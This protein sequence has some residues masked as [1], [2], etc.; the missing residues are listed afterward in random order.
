VLGRLLLKPPSPGDTGEEK[1]KVARLLLERGVQ[2]TSKE[3]E[4]TQVEVLRWFSRLGKYSKTDFAIADETALAMIRLLSAQ[5]CAV[6]VIYH[7]RSIAVKGN[8]PV[9]TLCVMYRVQRLFESDWVRLVACSSPRVMTYYVTEQELAL[10]DRGNG[11][12]ALFAILDSNTRGHHRLANVRALI[13]LGLNPA[14]M[15]RPGARNESPAHAL[16]EGEKD[17]LALLVEHGVDINAEDSCGDTMLH[18]WEEAR[19]TT[20]RGGR[21]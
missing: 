18:Y 12:H 5:E 15:R 4:D 6:H 3:Q 10:V 13:E 2:L 14:N 16:R 19:R 8:S 17:L 20:G 9:R 21:G 1:L 11:L 7:L